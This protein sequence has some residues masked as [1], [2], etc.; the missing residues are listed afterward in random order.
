MFGMFFFSLFFSLATP[1]K[2]R[3]TE[4]EREREREMANQYPTHYSRVSEA[5][6]LG[7]AGLSLQAEQAAVIIAYIEEHIK[8][9]G[10]PINPKLSF[11]SSFFYN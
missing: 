2:N 6:R 1:K 4:K 10:T 7:H 3:E 11:D 9:I 5:M 8:Q